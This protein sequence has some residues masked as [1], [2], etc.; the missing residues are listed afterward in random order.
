VAPKAKHLCDWC[1]KKNCG[2]VTH[3]CVARPQLLKN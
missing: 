3:L 2:P 1:D